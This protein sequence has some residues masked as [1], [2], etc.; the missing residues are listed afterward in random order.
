MDLFETPELL[1]KEVQDIINNFNEKELSYENCQRLVEDLEKV[2]Y[3]CE[4]GLDG[5]PFD[6]E[7]METFDFYVDAKVITWMRTNFEIK[8]KSLEEAKLKAV[9]F[10]KKGKTLDLPWNEVEGT[11][12]PIS[13]EENGFE[14]TEE[15]YEVSGEFIWDNT[16][17]FEETFDNTEE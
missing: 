16:Q 11:Y 8:A 1:P 15:M 12:E 6:L 4:Y 7:E 14:S 2:G 17:L 10:H 3:T 13:L 9:E 5:V